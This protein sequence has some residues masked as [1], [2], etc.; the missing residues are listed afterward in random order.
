MRSKLDRIVA[1]WFVLMIALPFTAPFPTCDF[2]QSA[3]GAQTSQHHVARLVAPSSMAAPF[4]DAE[5]SIV[6][7][8][9]AST[10]L[11][12]RPTLSA[13]D[14]GTFLPASL[15]AIG[16]RSSTSLDLPGRI[17]VLLTILRL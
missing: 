8:L 7:P 2:S 10:G 12:R 16:P 13:A 15:R 5:F 6:P 11:L 1:V 3:G 14:S 17:P 9:T 4:S